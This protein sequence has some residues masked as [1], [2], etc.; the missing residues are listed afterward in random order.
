[1]TLRHSPFPLSLSLFSL[2]L[3]LSLLRARASASALSL[4]LALSLTLTFSRALSHLLFRSPPLSATFLHTF[5]GRQNSS[6]DGCRQVFFLFIIIAAR[7]WLATPA[8]FLK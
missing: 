3:S 4:A 2:S 8:K 6:N 1:M 7:D 5:A